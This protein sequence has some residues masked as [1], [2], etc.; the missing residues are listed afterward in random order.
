MEVQVTT[1]IVL[2]TR[3]N[4]KYVFISRNIISNEPKSIFKNVYIYLIIFYYVIVDILLLFC[5]I[6][7]FSLL[8]YCKQYWVLIICNS[9]PL[10]V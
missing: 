7:H 6:E 10:A 8:L 4:K 2:L 3:N 5:L 9:V 1:K